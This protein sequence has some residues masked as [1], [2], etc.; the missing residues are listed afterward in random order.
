MREYSPDQKH[1]KVSLKPNFFR[2]YFS[3]TGNIGEQEKFW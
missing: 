3:N 2:P 1:G